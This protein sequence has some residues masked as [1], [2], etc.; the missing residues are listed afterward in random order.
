ML[1]A[2]I[3]TQHSMVNI[4]S[5]MNKA[6]VVKPS[7]MWKKNVVCCDWFQTRFKIQEYCHFFSSE[8]FKI[9]QKIID[10]FKEINL[11]NSFT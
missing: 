6:A 1:S 3:F 2:E 4:K 10:M 9:Q 11:W 8:S 5:S 7:V